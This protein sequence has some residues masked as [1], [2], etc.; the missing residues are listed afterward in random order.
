MWWNEKKRKPTLQEPVVG[1]VRV[2]QQQK[3]AV[4]ESNF[5]LSA[6]R[7]ALPPK[8]LE[9]DAKATSE[10]ARAIDRIRKDGAVI[11]M[12]ERLNQLLPYHLLQQIP[13]ILAES[14]IDTTST[15]DPIV[16]TDRLISFL[17]EKKAICIIG[18]QLTRTGYL[19]MTTSATAYDV[20]RDS[21]RD[22]NDALRR[23]DQQELS[24]MVTYAK[25]HLGASEVYIAITW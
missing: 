13:E 9:N 23:H 17:L 18:F 16:L 12:L 4:A 15:S 19:A 2:P 14:E 1:E 10:W 25:E 6:L 11:F 22:L 5:L 20:Y 21:P 24:R 3:N 8:G 7:Q